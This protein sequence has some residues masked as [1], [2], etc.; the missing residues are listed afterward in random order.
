MR[1]KRNL[2]ERIGLFCLFVFGGGGGEVTLLKREA[3]NHGRTLW[4]AETVFPELDF[5]LFPPD[6]SAGS[7]GIGRIAM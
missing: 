7:G 5:M 2:E 3:F 4:L 1:E 6:E